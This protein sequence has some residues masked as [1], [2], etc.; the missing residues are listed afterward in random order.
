MTEL[1][2]LLDNVAQDFE[3]HFSIIDD[4]EE[5]YRA[6][7]YDYFQDLKRIY[8]RIGRHRYSDISKYIDSQI[9][10]K[11]DGL[12]IGIKCIIDCAK[13]NEYDK[14]DVSS[15]DYIC[16][17]KICKLFDH[18]ELEAARYSSIKRIQMLAENN[19]SQAY[20][21]TEIMVKAKDTAE[22]AKKQAKNLSQQ[23]ISI[24]GIFA[25]IIV[26][27][28]FATTVVGET[29]ANLTKN[30]VVYLAFAVCVLGMVFFNIIALLMSFVM[31]LSGH[32]F[33]SDFP[34]RVYI[35]GTAML[36]L[37]AIFFYSCL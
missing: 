37:G 32:D 8:A 20:H 16:Y 17:K 12:C 11:V 21:A 33:K 30:D 13:A 6:I 27:F 34:A 23:L 31:K 36:L 4:N 25:G 19:S 3:F 15:E 26:T 28:S 1:I 24:L 18:V 5:A 10:D 7:A 29:I 14:D 2:S 35:F 22:E 9:Q